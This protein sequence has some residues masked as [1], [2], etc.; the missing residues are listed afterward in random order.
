[1]IIRTAR[2]RRQRRRLIARTGNRKGKPGLP[3]QNRYLCEALAFAPEYGRFYLLG[4]CAAETPEFAMQWLQARTRHIADQ[5]DPPASHTLQ[6]WLAH[7]PEHEWALTLLHHGRPYT[8]SFDSDGV[9]YY[10]SVR[11]LPKAVRMS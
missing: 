11:C 1:M 7:L 8:H 10:L 4:R 3:I 5:L 9:H 2:H 6:C